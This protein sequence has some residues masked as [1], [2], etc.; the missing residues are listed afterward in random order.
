MP[1]PPT[2]PHTHTDPFFSAH[3]P[4]HPLQ[5]Q[6]LELRPGSVP[7][8]FVEAATDTE[9]MPHRCVFPDEQAAIYCGWAEAALR[10]ARWVGG[11][12]V[13]AAASLLASYTGVLSDA[14]SFQAP[15]RAQMPTLLMP[16]LAAR[17]PASHL[18]ELRLHG[19][20]CAGTACGCYRAEAGGGAAGLT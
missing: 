14:M 12:V 20:R 5:Q 9:R 10:K 4:V 6:E 3:P 8:G 2:H 11:W 17:R 16:V 15:H 1:P 18:Q 19:L 7:S 13:A